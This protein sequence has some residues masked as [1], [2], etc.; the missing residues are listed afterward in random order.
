MIRTVKSPALGWILVHDEPTPPGFGAGSIP[1]FSLEELAWL[2]K[3]DVAIW[4]SVK[5][6]KLVFPA[7]QVIQHIDYRANQRRFEARMKRQRGW[8]TNGG[9]TRLPVPDP[10]DD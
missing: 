1:A 7:A 5:L 9:P 10:D 2:K 3:V 6:V 8:R 4:Q